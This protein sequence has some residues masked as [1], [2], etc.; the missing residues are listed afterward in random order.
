MEAHSSFGDVTL[1]R[2]RWDQT[3]S[4]VAYADL[5][6]SYSNVQVMEPGDREGMIAELCEMIDREFDG[7]VVRPLVIALAMARRSAD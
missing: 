7:Y 1:L 2:Y 5:L 3:Y 6:R 4:S